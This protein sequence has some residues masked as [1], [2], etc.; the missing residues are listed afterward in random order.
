M[1]KDKK[2]KKKKVKAIQGTPIVNPELRTAIDALKEGNTPERQAES[3]PFH[4]DQH[5]GRQNLFP[6]LYGY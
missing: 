6:C 5:K 4:S 1:A 3:D 2:K